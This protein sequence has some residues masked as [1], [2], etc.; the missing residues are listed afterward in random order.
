[1]A[2]VT[3]T[4][5][6]PPAETSEFLEPG[7]RVEVRQ[8]F[9]AGWARGFEICAVT[10][11]GYRVRRTSDDAELPVEFAAHEVRRERRRDSWWY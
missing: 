6:P 8:R 11:R 2:I 7:T 5:A 4:M 9:E 10:E 3:A 1:M